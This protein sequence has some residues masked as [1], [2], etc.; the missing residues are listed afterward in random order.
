M[1]QVVTIPNPTDPHQLA[2]GDR[3][4]MTFTAMVPHVQRER[5]YELVVEAASRCGGFALTF[6]TAPEWADRATEDR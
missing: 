5:F 4:H 3:D 6:H 1:K 2:L